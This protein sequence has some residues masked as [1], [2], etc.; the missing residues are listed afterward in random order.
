MSI[1]KHEAWYEA[2][3]TWTFCFAGPMGDNARSL[4]NPKAVLSFIVWADSHFQAMATYNNILGWYPYETTHKSDF[5]KYPNEW[6]NIQNQLPI[7]CGDKS[8]EIFSENFDCFVYPIKLMD[9]KVFLVRFGDDNGSILVDP[10]MKVIAFSSH[11]EAKEF[12]NR[13]LAINSTRYSRSI[14]LI[15]IINWTKSGHFSKPNCNQ[16]LSA[17]NLFKDAAFSIGDKHYESLNKKFGHVYEK[18]LWG[19]NL[20]TLTPEGNFFIPNWIEEE[21]S[22]IYKVIDYGMSIFLKNQIFCF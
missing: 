3:G 15:P 6:R 4:M 22:E 5:Q 16:C 12:C 7:A 2:D 14:N 9:R 19:N 18:L 8:A 21:F 20:P 13:N 11:E 1:L 17:W 10:N